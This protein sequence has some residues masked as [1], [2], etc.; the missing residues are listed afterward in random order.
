MKFLILCVLFIV[1][2]FAWADKGTIPLDEAGFVDNVKSNDKAGILSQ[3][4]EPASKMEIS[5][6][7]GEVFGSVWKYHNLNTT[8]TGAY[9]KT[10]ELD[11][12]GD[13][14]VSVVFSN[15]EDGDSKALIRP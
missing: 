15:V 14:V 5:G 4:G 7:D 8:E 12:V 11:F 2:V 13:Q 10:T 6:D 3:L 9:Y 1:P